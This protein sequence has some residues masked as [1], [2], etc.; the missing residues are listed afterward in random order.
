M[1][2]ESIIKRERGTFVT[3]DDVTYHFAPGADGCHVAEVAEDRH[4]EILLSI[5]EGYR[6]VVAPQKAE[7]AVATT[8]TPTPAT[9]TDQ[10]T[11]AA[12]K[13][14]TVPKKTAKADAKTAE[15]A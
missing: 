2:I 9:D 5:T 7:A 11:A 12:P 10:G 13:K 1:L 15:G 3:L 14:V 6:A 4:A 8:A